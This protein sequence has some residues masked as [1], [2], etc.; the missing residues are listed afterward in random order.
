MMSARADI[1]RLRQAA[2]DMGGYVNNV[3]N[4]F[5]RIYREKKLEPMDPEKAEQ[6]ST[7]AS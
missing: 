1:V 2:E 5:E 3:I 7:L 6:V 4:L